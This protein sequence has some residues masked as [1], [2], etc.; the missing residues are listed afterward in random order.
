V[1]PRLYELLV[2]TFACATVA[3]AQQPPQSACDFD[4]FDVSA[5][6]AEVVRPATAY[7]AC[8]A[9]KK[10]LTLQ[11]RPSD[12]VVI[13]R[14]EGEWTC[15]YVT[16]SRGAAPGW[17][18]S[19]DVRP[20][21]ADPNPPLSAWLGEWH[22]GENRITIKK[23][24]N[25]DKLSLDGQAYWRGSRDNVHDGSISGESAPQGNKLHYAEDGAD[26]CTVDFALISNY[27]LANDNNK[28]GGMNVRFWGVW[29]R[30]PFP[31]RIAK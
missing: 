9:G 17:V 3:H 10:C 7:Y 13:G 15:G 2:C 21:A 31:R 27:L 23:A 5:K 12:T 19:Q 11:L 22:Q 28:C 14:P 29:H 20:L 16:T 26:S 18:R 25:P 4:G 30:A 6:L 8:G 1:F 24:S